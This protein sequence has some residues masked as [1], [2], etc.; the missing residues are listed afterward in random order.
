MFAFSVVLVLYEHYQDGVLGRL[1]LLFGI[2]LPSG[3][4]LLEE[5]TSETTYAVSNGEVILFFGVALFLGRT[6]YN[7]WKYG[8][9]C[10][11][12]LITQGDWVG[13]RERRHQ[14][15]RSVDTVL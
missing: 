9:R 5:W 8:R 13:E 15:R 7:A 14:P 11:R 6:L 4:W 2:A 10:A 12:R 3:F 1:A